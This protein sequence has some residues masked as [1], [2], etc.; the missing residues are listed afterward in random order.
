MIVKT[1]TSSRRARSRWWHSPQ[2]DQQDPDESGLHQPPRRHRGSEPRSRSASCSR[3]F[4]GLGTDQA[5]PA[6]KKPS[7]VGSAAQGS[8]EDLGDAAAP[9]TVC[10]RRVWALARCATPRDLWIDRRLDPI[11]HRQMTGGHPTESV[12]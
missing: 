2:Q 9:F 12:T 10:G 3:R 1:P 7:R 5:M 8:H 6:F 11:D 4:S